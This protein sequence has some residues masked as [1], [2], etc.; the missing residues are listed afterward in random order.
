MGKTYK[1]RY[2][3]TYKGIRI[4]VKADSVPDLMR[5]LSDKKKQIDTQ[6]LS[7][8]MRFKE[9]VNMYLKTYKEN[10]VSPRWYRE[11][12]YIANSKIVPEIGNRPLKN[13]SIID[14]QNFLNSCAKHSNEYISKIYQLT[15]QIFKEAYK[16]NMTNVDYTIFL[17]RPKGHA[18]TPRRSIT[19]Y[20]REVLLNVLNG[21]ITEKYAYTHEYEKEPVKHRGNRI[22]K[23]MLY[24]G[25]R[26]KEA[27]NLTW[28]N[29]D[30]SRR[31]VAIKNTKTE[32]GNRLIPI[33]DHL[34]DELLPYKGDPDS[35]V[36][37]NNGKKY[38]PMA[39]RCLWA[40]IKRLMNIGMGCEVYRNKLIEPLPLADDFYMYNLRHTYCTDLEKAGVPINIASRLMGHSDISLTAKIYTHASTE[41]LEMARNLIN[42]NVETNVE[43][44][45]KTV[46]K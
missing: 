11:L 28:K 5:K 45:A 24:C 7:P 13:I 23:M 2:T 33:P 19:D 20:E 37:D 21:L 1:H 42:S 18:G 8:K 12:S 10:S 3:E 43:T 39:I 27:I 26:E 36:C 9:F 44:I 32:A 25:L 22:C 17:K 35:L 14:V 6:T 46:E 31:T 40:N 15:V 29:V 34:V 41:T 30:L 4:D 38:T 16:N